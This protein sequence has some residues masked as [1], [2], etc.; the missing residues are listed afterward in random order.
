MFQ[1][2]ARAVSNLDTGFHVELRSEY[3]LIS[4]TVQR[5]IIIESE[6]SSMNYVVGSSLLC[7]IVQGL[8]IS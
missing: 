5:A 6:V 2:S 3:V 4:N 1:C 7:Q 8:Q